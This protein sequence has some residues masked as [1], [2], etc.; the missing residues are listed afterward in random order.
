MSEHDPGTLPPFS[1]LIRS[2]REAMMPPVSQRKAARLAGMSDSTWNALERG[3]PQRS[4]RATIASAALV[5]SVTP[6]EL[7]DAGRPDA[8]KALRTLMQQ[9]LDTAEV[10]GGLREAAAADARAGLDGLLTEIVQGLADIEHSDRLSAR[11]KAELREELIAGIVRDIG[12]RR[13]HVRAMLRIAQ[14]GV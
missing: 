1:Q 13:D 4:T 2:K 9:R 11:Q 12:E 3:D 14:S 10:P 7:E 6:Q 8:A 5:V